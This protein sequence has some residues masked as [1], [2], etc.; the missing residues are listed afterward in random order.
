MTGESARRQFRITVRRAVV[1]APGWPVGHANSPPRDKL[2]R[3]RRPATPAGLVLARIESRLGTVGKVPLLL[4][5]Y[6][7]LACTAVPWPEPVHGGSPLWCAMVTVAMIGLVVLRAVQITKRTMRMIR[8]PFRQNEALIYYQRARGQQIYLL[9]AAFTAAMGLGGWGWAV[10]KVTAMAP[11][12]V[13]AP[14]AE[15]LIIAPFILGMVLCWCANYPVEQ[16]INWMWRQPTLTLWTYLSFQARQ[17]LGLVFLPVSLVVTEQSLLRWNPGLVEH[18][19]F[20]IVSVVAV[21]SLLIVAPW[22]MKRLMGLTSL[23][24]GP[25]RDR[26]IQGARRMRLRCSDILEWNTRGTTANAM[27]A[28]LL[29]QPRYV[30]F[31]DRLLEELTPEELEGVLG[32]EVGHV[33]HRHMLLYLTFILLSL[34]LL[35]GLTSAIDR[36]LSAY[37]WSGGVFTRLGEWQTLVSILGLAAYIVVAFGFLSRRCEREA[38]LFGCR[39]LSCGRTDCREHGEQQALPAVT[40]A[41]RPCPVGVATFISALERVAAVNGVSRTRPGWLSSWQHP[42][43]ARRVAFLERVAADPDLDRRYRRRLRRLKLVVLLSL[44]AGVLAFWASG[45]LQWPLS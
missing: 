8:Q 6:L 37:G 33:R 3:W 4:T 13:I 38:D 21:A 2:S 24:V 17:H 25:L 34:L 40:R 18:T 44:L 27:I 7:L 41:T 1:Q 32:H 9:M 30:L 16:E 20:R 43:I 35:S 11:N 36:W 5:L 29:P 14:G 39:A 12:D 28:G 42:T 15:M 22:I 10:I 19:W 26:L 45:D 23:P 31:T